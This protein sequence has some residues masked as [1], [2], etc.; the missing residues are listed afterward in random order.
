[1]TLGLGIT[2]IA[3][4]A[5]PLAAA[6]IAVALSLARREAALRDAGACRAI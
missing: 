3:L 5:L 1:M 4:V 6:W 2:G